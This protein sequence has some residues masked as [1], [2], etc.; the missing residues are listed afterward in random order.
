MASTSGQ[1]PFVVVE[2]RLKLLQGLGLGFGLNVG[3][4]GTV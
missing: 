3:D 4:H 1:V 2:E